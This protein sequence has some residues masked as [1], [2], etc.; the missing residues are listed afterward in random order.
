[1][2]SSESRKRLA[3]EALEKAA[4]SRK[5]SFRYEHNVMWWTEIYD[6]DLSSLAQALL[7]AE[8]EIERQRQLL[9]YVA[10]FMGDLD[11]RLG[12]D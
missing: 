1:M 4:R 11:K 7:E 6:R 9:E 10:I 3:E 8:K 5:V 2:S 12:D